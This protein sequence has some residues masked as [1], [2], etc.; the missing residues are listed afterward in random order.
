MT[1][2][3]WIALLFLPGLALAQDKHSDQ[4]IRKDIERHRQM[5]AAHEAAAKCLADGKKPEDCQKALQAA[6]KGLAI[7]KYC[8][9]RHEH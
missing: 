2:K 5:A 1:R 6:C 3:L 7:G 9:M 4:E 8:G